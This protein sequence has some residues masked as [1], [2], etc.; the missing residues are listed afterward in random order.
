MTTLVHLLA[1]LL[2]VAC[3]PLALVVA[4]FAVQVA[5]ATVAGRIRAGVSAPAAAKRPRI[6][7]LTPAHDEAEGIAEMLQALMPQLQPGDRVLV[8]AD[9][10]TDETSSIARAAG[11]VVVERSHAT[12]R[13]KSYALAFGVDAMR[14]DPPEVV[15]VVDADCR[16]RPGSLDELAQGVVRHDRPLQALDLM[17]ARPD[18]GLVRRFAEFAWRI[19]N[20]VRPAGAHRLGL[21]CQLMGTGMAFSWEMI[22]DARLATGSLAEDMKLGIDFAIQGRPPLFCDAAL[23]TSYFPDSAAAARSQRTRWEHGHLETIVREVPAVIWKAMVRT[24]VRLLGMALDLCVPPLA[25]LAM[26]L[27][28]LDGAGV[29]L[30]ALG[31]SAAVAV[32]AL[33]VTLMF[34][35]AALSAWAIRGRG[36]I[37]FA[38]LLSIPFYVLTKLPI[39]ARFLFRRQKDWVRTERK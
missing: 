23:V 36:L 17:I 33:S 14:D 5:A 20:W 27:I 18:A 38:E 34:V 35:A 13:G 39:Y 24:D 2:L 25:L 19:R 15:V 37:S 26:L 4:V 11:A 22:A 21:P 31:A 1:T 10:C 9:N 30:W 29:V 7:V 3:V 6:A 28:A 16:V 32:V 8:V 12:L